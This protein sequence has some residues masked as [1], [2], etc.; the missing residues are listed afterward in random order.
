MKN[1]NFKIA[2]V[3]LLALTLFNS[4][5]FNCVKG[6]GN[7]VSETRKADAFTSI[8]ISGGYTVILKQDS[9]FTLDITADDNLM[10]YI[11]TDV[12]GDKL[13]IS[14]KR[15][16]CSKRNLQI[17]IGVANLEEIRGSG[18]IQLTADRKLN[19]KD[20]NLNFSGAAKV[21]LDLNAEN[22][23]TKGS[24]STELRLTGQASR[25]MLKLTGAG[26]IDALDFVVGAYD[27]ETTGSSNCK[28]NVLNELNVHT[29]GAADV[30][31][32]GNPANVNTHKTGA[33]EI[34]RV[35]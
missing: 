8:D 25:H 31:Y 24:G 32:R 34:R 2:L 21:Q 16:L 35:E 10:K 18:A 15:G 23:I 20:L 30:Q 1:F 3:G 4:C 27:I 13:K 17:V 14:S 22:L 11:V 7:M 6:S 19:V 29:T 28:I 5:G 33:A 12:N 9:S 26:K